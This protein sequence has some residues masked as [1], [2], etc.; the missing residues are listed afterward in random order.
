MVITNVMRSFFLCDAAY[1]DLHDAYALYNDRC[2][3]IF[4]STTPCHRLQASLGNLDTSNPASHVTFIGG[5]VTRL[6]IHG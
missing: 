5:G 1:R 4:K 6:D 2:Q 3:I